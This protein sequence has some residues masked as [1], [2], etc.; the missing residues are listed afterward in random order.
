M[1]YMIDRRALKGPA[2]QFIATRHESVK[3]YGT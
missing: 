1:W 3:H 2:A